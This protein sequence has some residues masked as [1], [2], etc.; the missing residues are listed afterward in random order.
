M[1]NSESIKGVYML[2]KSVIGAILVT[3]MTH[4]SFADSTESGERVTQ[5]ERALTLFAQ[6]QYEEAYSLLSSLYLSDLSDEQLHFHLGLSAYETKRYEMALA[7]FERCQILN[8]QNKRYAYETGRTYYALGMDEDAQRELQPLREDPSLSESIRHNIRSYLGKIDQ[9]RQK[10]FFTAALSIGGVYD[11]NVNY[12][13]LDDSFYSPASKPELSDFG[14]DVQAGAE[15]LYDIGEKG[16]YKVRNRIALFNREYDTLEEY[17]VTYL[18]YTPT[19]LYQNAQTLYTLTASI[20][21]M[22]LHHESYLNVYSIIPGMVHELDEK[23][24]LITY[25]RYHRKYFLRTADEAKNADN[26][27]FSVGYQH[28][29][30]TAYW[31]IKGGIDRERKTDQ[32]TP[33]IDIDFNRYRLSG[34]YVKQLSPSLGVKGEAEIHTRAFRDHFTAFGNKREDNGYKGGV[35]LTQKFTPTMYAEAKTTYERT[36]SNQSV[37]AYDKHTCSVTLN[38]KF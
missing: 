15:H 35:S 4:V 19:L 13:P 5:K 10:S 11:S 6:Q 3:I 27:E 20:D 7:A 2:K 24:R 30:P 38:K 21:H 34:E 37:Y 18:S 32:N 9:H 28:T 22:W 12:G 8:P 36:W 16:G 25:F 1:S 33:R 29:V 26:Y 17:D 31:M 14:Y 23:S